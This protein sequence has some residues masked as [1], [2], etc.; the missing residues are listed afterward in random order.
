MARTV[1][2]K[3]NVRATAYTKVS[4]APHPPTPNCHHHPASVFAVFVRISKGSRRGWRRRAATGGLPASSAFDSP[5]ALTRAFVNGARCGGGAGGGD[6]GG[7]EVG[8]ALCTLAG[9]GPRCRHTHTARTFRGRVISPDGPDQMRTRR[10][11][12][13][14]ARAHAVAHSHKVSGYLG[15]RAFTRNQ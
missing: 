1:S 4:I 5:L 10:T 9:I 3:G 7:G 8:T 15:K 14:N 12:R 6:G 11:P 2:M 13:R